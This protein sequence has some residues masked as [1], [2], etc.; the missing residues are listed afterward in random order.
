MRSSKI[1]ILRYIPLYAWLL[2][3][4][5]LFGF[6]ILA[7]LSTTREIFSNTL[8]SGGLKW[9]NY[10]SLFKN[11]EMARY[12]FNSTFYTVAACVGIVIIAA[13]A[14][15]IV[16]RVNFFGKKLVN[17]MFISAMSIP[18]MLIAIPIFTLFTQLN[19]TGSVATLVLIYIATSVPYGV[20]LL[21]GFFSS[22]PRELEE[23]AAVDGCGTIRTFIKVIMPM[24]Q[25]GIIT[26]TI[27]NFMSIWNEY[28]YA[29][30]FANNP[31]TYTLAL[32]L[33]FIVQGFTNTGNYAGIFAAAMIVF[34]PTFILYIFISK[35][36]VAGITVGAVKG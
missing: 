2:F 20:F 26:L 24:A 22:I 19:L 14:A 10:S 29:L 13:P 6:A 32:A 4:I 27:F 15:Y 23:A 8:L 35:K 9:S 33:Q 21:S 5:A 7:S 36:I 18:G 34:L 31:K 16:G 3:L 28:F 17:M 11:Q 30:I 25:P 12:F 1:A